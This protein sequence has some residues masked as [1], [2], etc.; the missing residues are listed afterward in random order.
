LKQQEI[1]KELGEDNDIPDEDIHTTM[2]ALEPTIGE[3][4]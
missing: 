4:K 3:S 1:M 2:L